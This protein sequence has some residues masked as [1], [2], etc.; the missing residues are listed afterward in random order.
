MPSK[1][2]E[3]SDKAAAEPLTMPIAKRS[4]EARTL[5]LVFTVVVCMSWW[6]ERA[7]SGFF[8]ALYTFKIFSDLQGFSSVRRQFFSAKQRALLGF[9][10]FHALGHPASAV[11]SIQLFSSVC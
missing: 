4:T 3:K 9:A 10:T 1:F 6:L 7:K 11:S 2:S 5:S 8:P